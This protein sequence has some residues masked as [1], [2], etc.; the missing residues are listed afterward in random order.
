M[1][2][3]LP[4]FC[5]QRRPTEYLTNFT[6]GTKACVLKWQYCVK[7]TREVEANSS[8]SGRNTEPSQQIAPLLHKTGELSLASDQRMLNWPWILVTC[9][10]VCSSI[11][12]IFKIHCHDRFCCLPSYVPC[13]TRRW[14]SSSQRAFGRRHELFGRC[15]V[16]SRG[17]C[18]INT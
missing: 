18:C 4:M 16:A 15:P 2:V 11:L 13:H 3:A 10:L 6:E 12:V 7:D 17:H 5:V 9:S 8:M 1:K 14:I